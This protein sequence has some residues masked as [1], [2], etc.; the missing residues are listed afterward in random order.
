MTPLLLL[1]TGV[2]PATAVPGRLVDAGL[3]DTMPAVSGGGR[4]LVG[5]APAT[6]RPRRA[7]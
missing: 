6:V 3:E 2:A 4:A 5:A 7:S 1:F